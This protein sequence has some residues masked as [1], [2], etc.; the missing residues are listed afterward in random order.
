MRALAFVVAL[1]V[2]GGCATKAQQEVSRLNDVAVAGGQA[3]DACDQRLVQGAPYQALKAK[4]GPVD[5][6]TPIALKAN[7]DKAIPA[8]VQALYALHQDYLTPCRK[9]RIETVAKLHPDLVAILAE[10]YANGDANLVRLTT[11]QISWGEYLTARDAI[12]TDS[13]AKSVAVFSTLQK[14]LDVAHASELARRQ[15]A[16]TALSNWAHQQQV[17][18]QQQQTIDATNPPRTTTC[19]YVGATLSCTTS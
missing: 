12:S 7:K 17:L 1:L 2:L 10:T 13:K 19:R 16:A 15:V 6:A 14:N 18:L 11:R 9:I 5:G 8:E 3:I 4:L